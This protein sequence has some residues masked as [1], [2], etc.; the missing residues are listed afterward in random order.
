[1]TEKQFFEQQIIL[2]LRSRERKEQLTG[3]RYYVG[4]QDILRRQRTAIVDGG[5]LEVV[6]NLPKNQIVY[7]QYS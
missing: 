1:M 5:K 3:E 2:W 6:K 4:E 7:N